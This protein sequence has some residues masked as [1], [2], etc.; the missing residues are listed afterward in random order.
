MKNYNKAKELLK[1]ANILEASI[2]RYKM[3]IKRSNCDKKGA[4]WNLDDRFSAAHIAL[5]LDS[6]LGYYGDGS[7]ATAISISD[8][9]IFQ[10]AFVNILNRMLWQIL[11]ATVSELRNAARE[12]KTKALQEMQEM[13]GLIEKI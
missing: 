4:G 5:S 6:W 13:K 2:D 3:E 8:Q 1:V 12:Y 9:Q 11:D 7:C 10:T